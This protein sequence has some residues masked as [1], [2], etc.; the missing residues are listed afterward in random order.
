MP[1]PGIADWRRE[2]FMFP[3]MEVL[4]IYR[5]K[6]TAKARKAKAVFD[7]VRAFM[8]WDF[9]TQLKKVWLAFL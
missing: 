3:L 7:L 8:L 9:A 6:E 5:N 1:T 4:N 2:K